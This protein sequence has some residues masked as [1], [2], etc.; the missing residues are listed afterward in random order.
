MHMNTALPMNGL[1][2][3][4][5][6][7]LRC[8]DN[9]LTQATLLDCF[10]AVEV[11]HALCSGLYLPFAKIKDSSVRELAPALKANQA[12]KVVDLSHNQIGPQGARDLAEALRV[13]RGLHTLSLWDNQIGNEGACALAEAL[14][15]NRGLH[16]LLLYGNHI[17]NEGVSALVQA[18]RV[19]FRLLKIVI[20]DDADRQFFYCI[21]RN[22]KIVP[23]LD[24]LFSLEKI[25]LNKQLPSVDEVAEIRKRIQ[26]FKNTVSE[27]VY[28][29]L[30]VD[31]ESLS[32]DSFSSYFTLAQAIKA[33]LKKKL[34]VRE[35][36]ELNAQSFG[37]DAILS[38]LKIYQAESEAEEKRLTP[39]TWIQELM[40]RVPKD[41]PSRAKAHAEA[42][43]LWS[44]KMS[45]LV[46][47]EKELTQETLISVFDFL[48]H[49]HYARKLSEGRLKVPVELET[50]VLNALVD[51]F[52][53]LGW[54]R[55]VAQA[56]AVSQ[57]MLNDS[58]QIR[59]CIQKAWFERKPLERI[60][61]DASCEEAPSLPARQE[62]K[63]DVVFLVNLNCSENPE[64][65]KNKLKETYPGALIIEKIL[66]APRHPF[67]PFLESKWVRDI[68]FENAFEEKMKE[69][70]SRYKK[71]EINLMQAKKEA[72]QF[73]VQAIAKSDNER[74]WYVFEAVKDNPACDF[75]H[76]QRN[77]R[78]DK[79]R[80]TLF[81]HILREDGA[82]RQN[83]SEQTNRWWN[84]ATF[85]GIV[86]EIKQK[87][88]Q[89]EEETKTASPQRRALFGFDGGNLF[90]D[91]SVSLERYSSR[92]AV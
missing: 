28:S 21:H 46:D 24:L 3:N 78:W 75:I 64:L 89:N 11:N 69:I 43:S 70:K 54:R 79:F 72:K 60:T 80:V 86:K 42:A 45:N 50:E 17:E 41:H 8:V 83:K 44:L 22:E 65:Y 26:F 55:S 53:G 51:Y 59:N 57:D 67:E 27:G 31:L 88:Q 29:S 33:Y 61:F 49:C 36:A 23:C 18:M 16:T 10:K 32:L 82:A 71:N 4:Q 73:I 63:I 92:M 1:K 56:A 52:N 7:E 77:T 58:I 25:I 87:W 34:S 40:E 68:D 5:Y 14:R 90:H 38:F 35:L 66:D 47:E 15:V 20:N 48:R 84:T 6:G 62:K 19:N 74:L 81:S 37:I 30:F 39:S 9:T 85:S 2:V 91:K 12:I 76:E 13:N